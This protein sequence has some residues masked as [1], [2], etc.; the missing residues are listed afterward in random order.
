[1]ELKFR[2]LK[3]SEVEARVGQINKGG[4]KILL[5]KDARCDQSI[6]DETVGPMNWQK[7]Y[8]NG[9]RNCTISIYD[10]E[11]N[12]WVEKEDVGTEPASS[13][14]KDAS[15]D[16]VDKGLASDAQK[17]AGFA[18]GIGRALYSASRLNLFFFSSELQGWKAMTDET[19]KERYSCYS[20]FRVKEIEYNE[21]SDTIKTVTIEE[22]Y[23]GKP[24]IA[25][26]FPMPPKTTSA[27]GG[28]GTPVQSRGPVNQPVPQNAAPMPQQVQQTASMPVTA[29]RPQAETTG[30]AMPAQAAAPARPIGVLVGEDEV[31][32]IGNCRGRKYGEAKSTKDFAS[33][34]EWIRTASR[35]YDNPLQQDQF[36]RMKKLAMTSQSQAQAFVPA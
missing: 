35:N 7:K 16:M 12:C 10:A 21:D 13:M 11:K 1:M 22:V 25:K 26:V 6:L 33:F 36:V 31:I 17:R 9:N 30:S 5:Y 19:G 23:N 14:S 4:V 18:W 34:M 29:A 3:A 8:S 15:K 27:G 32:L 28:P 20:T 2:K 24:G